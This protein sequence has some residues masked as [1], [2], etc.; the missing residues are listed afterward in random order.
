MDWQW[1]DG[2]VINWH[3]NGVLVMDFQIG[4]GLALNWWIG[5][6]LGVWSKFGMGMEDW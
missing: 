5:D 2:L 4:L 6:G 1:I 3:R